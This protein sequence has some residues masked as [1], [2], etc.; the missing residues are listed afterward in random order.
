MNEI[1]KAK[2]Q[3]EKAKARL[4]KAQSRIAAAERKKDTRRKII[5]G[6]LI[7]TKAKESPQSM[8]WIKNQVASLSERDRELFDDWEP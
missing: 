2:E 4:R 6:G 5:L 3:F 8:E 1:E 7:I